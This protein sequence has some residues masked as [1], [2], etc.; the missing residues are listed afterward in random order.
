MPSP[1]P[2]PTGRGRRAALTHSKDCTEQFPLPRGEGEE[3]PSPIAR[4]ARNSSLSHGE[5]EKGSPHPWQG[6]HGTVPSPTG[7]GRRAALIHGKD[8][9][10]QFPL[11][12]GEGEEQP[13]PIA[14]IARNSSL[15]HGEREK[16][17]P[18]PWQGLHGTVPSPTG[19]GRRA[20][21]IHGK[22][23][24]EQF[25]LPRGEG[26]GQSSS[27]ARIARNSSLSHARD[28]S[29]QSPLPLGGG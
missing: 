21:L 27:M 2:S 23:C 19:K 9:T 18:H 12:R 15:S 10:E 16:S 24:T 13:S 29:E 28:C 4:I 20:A 8:C 5:R 25:P 6:L 26:E 1:W 11:T 7:R 14:R 22:D 3:Q 17:S